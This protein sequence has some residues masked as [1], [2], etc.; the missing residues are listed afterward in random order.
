MLKRR[1]GSSPVTRT[2]T[3]F[4]NFICRCGGMA[5]ALASGASVRKDVG[6][7]VP[8]SA[9]CR[10]GDFDTT[11]IKI[12][13]PAFCL[14]WLKTVDSRTFLEKHRYRPKRFTVCGGAFLLFPGLLVFVC[15]EIL[16]KG[17]KLSGLGWQKSRFPLNLWRGVKTSSASI[18]TKISLR[19]QIFLAILY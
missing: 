3:P 18:Q 11:S 7:Q 5:D 19:S 9:P 13:V 1:T 2:I 16:K 8:P 14:Y 4:W 12:S 10:D 15:V 6:V 17:V